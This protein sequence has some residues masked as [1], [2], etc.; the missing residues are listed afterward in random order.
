M[1]ESSFNLPFDEARQTALVLS[2]GLGGL[3]HRIP[4]NRSALEAFTAWKTRWPNAKQ[5]DFI[6]P[7]EKLVFKGKGAVKAGVMT[8]ID[9]GPNNPL[10]AWKTA[11]RTAKKPAGVECRI[12]DLRRH[13]LTTLPPPEISDSTILAIAGHLSRKMLERY[14]HIRAQA[15]RAA[16]EAIEKNN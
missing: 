6:F 13:F 2:G 9:L 5:N 3:A 15:K 12:H 4:L 1:A 7:S 10:G 11:W 8:P 16:V 14:S